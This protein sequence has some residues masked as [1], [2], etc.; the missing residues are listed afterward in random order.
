MSAGWTATRL[1][2]LEEP[3]HDNAG[4]AEQ[5]EPAEDID[6]GPTE[7][8]ALKLPV[9]HG[10]RWMSSVRVTEE[11]AERVG[12]GSETVLEVLASLRDGIGHEV[13]MNVAAAGQQG[14]SE[15]YTDRSSDVSH[16]VEESAGIA[17]LLIVQ[18]AVSGGIDRDE[19]E[20]KA[21]S[22]DEDGEEQRRR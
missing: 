4:E 17:D 13:L 16:E 11:A 18:G 22:G 6:E 3:D 8:L 1:Y 2:L 21:E 15:R 10:L 19:D 5:R 7:R 14:R 12:S 20:A 9:E